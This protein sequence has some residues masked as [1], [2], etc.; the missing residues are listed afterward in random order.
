MIDLLHDLLTKLSLTSISDIIEAI[1]VDQL[2]FAENR[3]LGTI[4][5]DVVLIFLHLLELW[6]LN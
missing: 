4:D 6:H 1:E 5:S 2:S 3:R